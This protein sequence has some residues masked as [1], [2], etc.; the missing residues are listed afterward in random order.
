MEIETSPSLRSVRLRLRLNFQLLNWKRYKWLQENK[1]VKKVTRDRASAYA[2][3]ISEVLP[4]A[5]QI[6]DRFHLHQNL[7]KAV[8]EAMRAELP[9]KIAIPNKNLETANSIDPK[10]QVPVETSSQTVART[11]SE[12][13]GKKT[14]NAGNGLS[15][16]E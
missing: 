4:N 10:E 13:E 9:N 6:A 16:A 15:V 3:V 14:E 7:L 1:H 5:M 12:E 2:K 8:K 11:K